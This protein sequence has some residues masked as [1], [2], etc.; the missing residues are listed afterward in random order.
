MLLMSLAHSHVIQLFINLMDIT[1]DVDKIS[2]RF[3]L[4]HDFRRVLLMVTYRSAEL[5][6]WSEQRIILR[7]SFSVGDSL[8]FRANL[9]QD[10]TALCDDIR[11]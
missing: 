1:S 6:N 4:M 2:K 7:I 3:S 8:L 9:R 10:M 5:G 11:H